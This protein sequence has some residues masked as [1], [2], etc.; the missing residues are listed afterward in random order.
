[1]AMARITDWLLGKVQARKGRLSLVVSS[2]SLAALYVLPAEGTLL[3]RASAF[4]KFTLLRHTPFSAA[5]KLFQKDRRTKGFREY[6]PRCERKMEKE[7]I[8]ELYRC[9]EQWER[10]ET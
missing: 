9:I 7:Q 2:S 5:W 6:C 3:Q 8:D 10:E 4:L 1:M